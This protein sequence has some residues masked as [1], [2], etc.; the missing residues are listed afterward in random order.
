M[1]SPQI[2]HCH[3]GDKV[4]LLE[5]AMRPPDALDVLTGKIV[6]VGRLDGMYVNATDEDGNRVYIAAWTRVKKIG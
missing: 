5:D 1:D 3:S 6:T 4:M 2:M